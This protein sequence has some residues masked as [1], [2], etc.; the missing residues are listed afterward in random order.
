M[1]QAAMQ[2]KDLKNIVREVLKQNGFGIGA[3][4][5]PSQK[6]R[7]GC[8]SA[9]K[10]LNVFHPGVR[11]LEKALVQVRMIAE[12]TAKSSVFTVNSARQWVCGNDVKQKSGIRCILDHVQP[13]GIEK[14]LQK[15][16]ILVLPT[17]CL[18]TAAKVARL[19]GD[20]Q[21]SAIVLGALVQGKPVLAANDGF[22]L[23]QALVNDGIRNEI[24]RILAK[25]ESF[26]MVFCGTEQLYEVF[27]H[28]TSPK[29]PAGSDKSERAADDH[30][31]RGLKLVTAK[32]I[33][34]AVNRKQQTIQL[35]PGGVITPLARDLAKEYAIR[36]E[37]SVK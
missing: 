19:I 32:D 25:L 20:D 35:L 36:I 31:P 21:A 2:K 13:G 5:K 16:D 33:Q 6:R 8:E 22:S 29:P 3:T 12:I 14:V 28:M 34:S 30:P 15:V 1:K 37:A 9:P 23:C 7:S 26:G 17:F 4:S 27:K 18:K 10:V 11:K 24:K